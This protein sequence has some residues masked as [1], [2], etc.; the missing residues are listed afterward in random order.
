LSEEPT[1]RREITMA[2]DRMAVLDM[3]R[4]ATADGNVDILHVG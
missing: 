3:L 2:E 1:T 4:K